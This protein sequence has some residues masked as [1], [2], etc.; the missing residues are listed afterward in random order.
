MARERLPVKTVLSEFDDIMVR[1]A[2]RRELDRNGQVFV[3]HN[4]VRGIKMGES[5]RRR[6]G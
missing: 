5:V 4:R 6:V 2:I 1:Q 3:V